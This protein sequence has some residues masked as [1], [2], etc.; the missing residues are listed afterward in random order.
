MSA[1]RQWASESVVPVI[2]AGTFFC[3]DWS[4]V[5]AIGEG[6]RPHAPNPPAVVVSRVRVTW[7]IAVA[8]IAVA[9]LAALVTVALTWPRVRLVRAETHST[10]TPRVFTQTY[11]IENES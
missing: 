6:L 9:P 11:W 7:R 4:D 1:A 3:E 10:T 8:L 2:F 5:V